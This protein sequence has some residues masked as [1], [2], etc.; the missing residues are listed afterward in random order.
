[1]FTSEE[2]LKDEMP[3]SKYKLAIC[4]GERRPPDMITGKWVLLVSL[5]A[6]HLGKG[7]LVPSESIAVTCSSP[8]PLS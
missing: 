6:K 7:C 3:N 8:T 4:S 1:M 2:K 5:S